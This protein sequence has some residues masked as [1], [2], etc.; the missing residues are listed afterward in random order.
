[1]NADTVP[2]SRYEIRVDTVK[3]IVNEHTELDNEAAFS[4]AVHMVRA[5]D[6]VPE[7][8]R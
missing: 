1:M 2:V 3:K 6:T 5:L 8:V 7:P 4:L